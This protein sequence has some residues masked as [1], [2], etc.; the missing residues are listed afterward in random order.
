M[1]GNDL[2]SGVQPR[3]ILVFEGLIAFLPNKKAEVTYGASMRFHRWGRAVNQF[4]MNEHM[5]HRIYDVTYNKGYN[6]EALTFL[7][8]PMADK[9]MEWIDEHYLPVGRVR[10]HSPDELAKK[11]A[12]M[13]DVAAIYHPFK[14]MTFKFG[15]KGRYLDPSGPLDIIGSF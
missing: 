6:V 10:S 13:P 12:Y 15:G 5:E 8:D 7:G 4:V 11:V 1:Q 14:D 2:G 9:I 3:L